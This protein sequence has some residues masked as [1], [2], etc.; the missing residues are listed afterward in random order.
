MA[1]ANSVRERMP[2]LRSAVVIALSVDDLPAAMRFWV[3]VMGFE[4]TTDTPSLGFVVHRPSRIA[5]AVTNHDGATRGGFD[6]RRCG[7]DHLAFAVEGVTEL[8][9][10]QQR[11]QD[12]GVAHSPIT[13]SGAGHHLN[14]RAPGDIPIE[15]YVIDEATVAAFGLAGSD[16][17]FAGSRV[18]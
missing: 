7:L 9:S 4:V 13:D 17:A 12:N 18:R 6:E 1:T 2:R 14:L 5:I 3:E 15:L 8:R 11:L 10:W 16:E